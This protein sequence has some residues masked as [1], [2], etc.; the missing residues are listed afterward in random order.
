MSNNLNLENNIENSLPIVGDNSIEDSMEAISR[1]EEER[2]T[3]DNRAY[4]EESRNFN[5]ARNYLPIR[6]KFEVQCV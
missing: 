2:L 1:R 6:A 5:T 3:T 4:F